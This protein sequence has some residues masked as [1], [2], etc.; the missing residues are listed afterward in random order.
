VLFPVLLNYFSFISV[1]KWA[2]AIEAVLAFTIFYS[3]QSELAY[4]VV[5]SLTFIIQASQFFPFTLLC[6]DEYGPVLGPKV[7]SYVAFGSM[8]ACSAPVFYFTLIVKNFGYHTS[9]II[10]GLQ[11]LI[12]LL[13]T[14]TLKPTANRNIREVPT[15][16]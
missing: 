11:V 12:G 6:R 5:V 7:F 14:F 2:L 1:N 3:V 4:T 15:K 10:Q 8:L 13:L 9:F 16:A